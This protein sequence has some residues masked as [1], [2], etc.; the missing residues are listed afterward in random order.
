MPRLT[1]KSLNQ[2][3]QHKIVLGRHRPAADQLV[4]L[5]DVLLHVTRQFEGMSRV[6]CVVLGGHCELWE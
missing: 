6:V 1:L 3:L 4:P 2:P 5:P